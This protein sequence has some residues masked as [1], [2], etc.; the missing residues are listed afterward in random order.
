MNKIERKWSGNESTSTKN[1][2]AAI[3]NMTEPGGPEQATYVIHIRSKTGALGKNKRTLS[4]WIEKGLSFTSNYVE[5][6]S[7]N[8]L[9]LHDY[10]HG[11]NYHAWTIN[12]GVDSLSQGIQTLILFHWWSTVQIKPMQDTTVRPIG[13]VKKHAGM[14]RAPSQCTLRERGLK[15][16]NEVTLISLR[17]L[18]LVK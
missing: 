5:P 6:V 10:E 7:T 3:T 14:A 4:Y 15:Q 9:S 1:V 18:T 13:T 8:C 11:K 16:I 12:G 2:K 17:Y